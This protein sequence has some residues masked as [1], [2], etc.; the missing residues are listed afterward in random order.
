[1]R[2]WT[3]ACGRN[4]PRRGRRPTA[5]APAARGPGWRPAARASARRV[6]PVETRKRRANAQPRRARCRAAV[7]LHGR[8]KWRCGRGGRGV[9][10]A[11]ARAM[12]LDRVDLASPAPRE[13]EGSSQSSSSSKRRPPRDAWAGAFERAA[14]TWARGEPPRGQAATART[15]ALPHTNLIAQ[16]AARAPVPGPCLS[17]RC[18]RA[19]RSPPRRP[20][21]S[22]RS[23]PPPGRPCH[24]SRTRHW[25]MH[26]LR[27]RSGPRARLPVALARPRRRRWRV[28]SARAPLLLRP[29]QWP[30]RRPP[31]PP[32][33]D[34]ARSL[35][36]CV[37]GMCGQSVRRRA[38]TARNARA[39]A[40]EL[41][42]TRAGT[43]SASSV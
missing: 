10:G 7:P 41:R 8:C 9:G 34:H 42:A 1:V 29:L 16:A 25:A 14:P 11:S 43:C 37:A 38:P 13:P 26:C 12:E 3:W 24:R 4:G 17:R 30:R 22:S 28:F 39:A 18:C 32:A 27:L 23:S 36:L 15:C 6:V 19:H 35:V 31:P 33:L 20:A 2:Q 5:R 21:R 40:A